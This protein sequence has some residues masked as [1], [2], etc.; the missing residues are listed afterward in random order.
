LLYHFPAYLKELTS[1]FEEREK[2]FGG[3]TANRWVWTCKELQD[4]LA[5]VLI[6]ATKYRPVTIFVDAL[7]EYGEDPAKSLL[8]YFNNLVRQFEQ[9]KSLV[10]ICLSSR[11]YPVL[12]LGTTP[13]VYVEERNSEDIQWYVQ[14]RLKASLLGINL[15]SLQS[16]LEVFR[17]SEESCLHLSSL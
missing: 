16:V 11:H 14:E 4:F 5:I 8:E 6:K 17:I 3:Y 15:T 13:A 10:K 2:R 12:G 7:D 9:E 1:S